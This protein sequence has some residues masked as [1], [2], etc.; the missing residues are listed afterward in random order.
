MWF[1]G[2]TAFLQPP[3]ASRPSTVRPSEVAH[4]ANL[5]NQPLRLPNGSVLRN[6]LAKAAMSEALA[7]YGNRPTEALVQLYR[8][9]GQRTGSDRHGQRDDRSA[10]WENRATSSSRTSP[11][12]L[13]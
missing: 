12:C 5:L 6:R 11:T 1:Q 9:W 2:L 13:S 7:T 4:E 10:H 8:R 3:S